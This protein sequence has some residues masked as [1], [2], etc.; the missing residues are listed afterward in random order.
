MVSP[1]PTQ[2]RHEYTLY[3]HNLTL[4][5]EDEAVR[6]ILLEGRNAVSFDEC[7]KDHDRFVIKFRLPSGSRERSNEV[8]S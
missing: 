2:T 7:L 8:L 3:R 4:D 5:E 1:S 6:V